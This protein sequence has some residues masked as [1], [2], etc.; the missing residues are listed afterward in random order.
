MVAPD[1]CDPAAVADFR[2]VLA[3]PP[4]LVVHRSVAETLGGNGVH[5]VESAVEF[6]SELCDLAASA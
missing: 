4:P 1:S 3:S 6:A 5:I 2:D